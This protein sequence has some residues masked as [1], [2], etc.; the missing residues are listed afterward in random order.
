[1]RAA[2]Q[3]QIIFQDPFASLN[4]RMRVY[5]ILEDGLAA[6]QPGLDAAQRRARLER[7]IDPVG[8]RRDALMRNFAELRATF[9]SVDK[10]GERYV[11]NLGGNKYRMV[12]G[13]DFFRSKV[14]VKAVLTHG[15]YDKDKWK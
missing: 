10:V 4:P 8:L 9:G 15:E 5:E 2:R 13:V 7:L 11:F 3:V 14:W 6:L 1:M 12:V